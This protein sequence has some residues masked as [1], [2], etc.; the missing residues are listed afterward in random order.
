MIDSLQRQF[1]LK[2]RSLINITHLERTIKCPDKAISKFI[3][4]VMPLPD[5]WAMLLRDALYPMCDDSNY[6]HK[7]FYQIDKVVLMEREDL[8]C[9][10]GLISTKNISLNHFP[11]E[12]TKDAAVVYFRETGK[13]GKQKY[14]SVYSIYT[15]QN[16]KS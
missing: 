8:F 3:N 6:R 2:Y 5:K 7:T 12:S 16:Q 4:G 14:V 1:L 15:N 11:A 9:K 13:N 10:F